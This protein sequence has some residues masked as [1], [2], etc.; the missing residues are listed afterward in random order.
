[1]DTHVHRIQKDSHRETVLYPANEC[2]E[3]NGLGWVDDMSTG[4]W[5]RRMK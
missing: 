1:M 5:E 3:E 2:L 4:I